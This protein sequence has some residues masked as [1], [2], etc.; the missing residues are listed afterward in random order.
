M[1]KPTIS[2]NDFEKIDM[3]VGTII[4]AQPF[5]KAKNP[6]YKLWIDFGAE[7]GIRKTSAQITVLYAVEELMGK[8]IVAVVNFPPKQIADFMS[9]CLVL[10]VVASDKEVTLLAPGKK[11]EN[12]LA[13]G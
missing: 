3:R 1:I 6:A 2:W 12:G 13:I 5:E 10:G 4:D 7:I 8:Q 9:E 11:V